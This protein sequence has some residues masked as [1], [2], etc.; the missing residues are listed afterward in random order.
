M[1][2]DVYNAKR[3]F[4]RTPEPFGAPGQ[5]DPDALRFVVNHHAAK[6]PHFDLRLEWG[7]VLMSWAVPEGPSLDPKDKRLAIRTEDHPLEYLGFE[8]A[9][10]D[11]EYGA[12]AL[13]IWDHGSWVPLGADP[14]AEFEAGEIKFRLAGARLGGGWMLKKLPDEEKPWLLIKE[15]DP[16]VV[17]GFEIDPA[18]LK[19]RRLT[20]PRALGVKA[21]LPKRLSPQ[22]PSPVDSPPDRLGWLH[23]IKFDG[24]R[25]IIRKDGDRVKFITRQGLDWTERYE[26]LIP[27]VQALDCDTALL[28]G[29]VAAQDG[30]GA[31]SLELLQEALSAGRDHDLIFYAF[32][33]VH[34]DGRDLAELPLVTRKAQLRRLVPAD[35]M[36]RVQ[37]SDHVL[38]DGRALFAQACRLGL[39][40][41][42]SKDGRAKYRQERTKTWLKAKRFDVTTLAIIGFTTKASSRHVASIILA[43]ETEAG[44]TYVGRAGTGLTLDETRALF[45]TLTPLVLDKAPIAVPK[46]PNAHF[47]APGQFTAE[48]SYRGRTTKNIIRQAAILGITAAAPVAERPQKRLITDRDLANI[49]LTNP[50]R[51]M[52]EGSGTS[53]LDIALYYARVGEVM[54]PDL[55]DRPVTLIRCSTGK[56][57]DCFYQ[58]HGFSGL[59]DGVETMGDSRDEEFL[60]IKSAKGFLGLPQFGVL[61]FHPWDC[62]IHDLDHPDRLTID[63]DPGEGVSWPA[64]VSAAGIV[65][66]TL[67]S[68]GLAGFVR[69]TGGSG[70][71]IVVPLDGRTDW[72]GVK[73]FLKALAKSLSADH[74]RLFTD[75]IRKSARTGRIYVDTARTQFGTS[76]VAS[77]SLRARR[78]FPAAVPLSWHDLSANSPPTDFNRKKALFHVEKTLAH[79]WSDFEEARGPISQKTRRAVGL[80]A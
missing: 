69:L 64:T 72:A 53:K 70:V 7:G 21:D 32:D 24:Y 45:Q 4:M 74:P 58:R 18:P 68:L 30:R 46:T 22:L 40:G 78:D 11:G 5:S 9:I 6:R 38:G 27:H 33:L 34:L 65:R 55:I 56:E 35:P 1:G 20:R 29:E 76:A 71:H 62:T 3:R 8:G 12:G 50:D 10:P 77:Y 17:A 51:E 75:T 79:P 48:I 44:L 16:S 25:T 43:E 26:A 80:K 54:L 61:E 39:E 67:S 59:P 49:R 2:L 28:D 52:F 14:A 60:V 31:T 37:F 66:E 36:C 57:A 73:G 23:E 41:V 19:D 13:R 42:V 63:L 15:R 47:I